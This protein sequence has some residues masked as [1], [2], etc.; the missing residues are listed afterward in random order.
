MVFFGFGFLGAVSR[1]PLPSILE[2][3]LRWGPGGAEQY[4]QMICLVY[5]IWGFFLIK[6]SKEAHDHAMFLD[7]TLVADA[8]HTSLM[9][10]M[11]ITNASDRIHL[12]GDVL[13]SWAI[14]LPF[15]YFWV[16]RP[17]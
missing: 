1:A 14:L 4:E 8:A 11:A 7:F 12:L 6:A 15:G 16:T 5:F 13:G 3:L 2:S 17:Q 10:M 9:M